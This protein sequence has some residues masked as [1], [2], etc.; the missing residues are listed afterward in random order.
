MK[1]C[2][3][4]FTLIEL[5]L[6]VVIISVGMVGI[7]ALFE[8]ATRGAIQI[9]LNVIASNL[10]REKLERIILA[11]VTSGYGSITS[12]AYP[13][14]T[15]TG[16]LS[17]Y[18]RSTNIAEVASSDLITPE[19]SSGYKRVTVTVVWGQ[20]ANQRVSIPTIISNY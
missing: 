8:N 13:N 11:K 1:L 2:R 17:V 5:L 18:T 14:E 7:M 3:R 4:G 12:N 20:A 15:F 16:D 19:P 9:D 10:A 6:T